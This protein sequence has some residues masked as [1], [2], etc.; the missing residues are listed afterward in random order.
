MNLN[1]HVE[2]FNGPHEEQRKVPGCMCWPGSPWVMCAI[3]HAACRR[4]IQHTH[5]HCLTRPVASST[6][7]PSIP[8]V[9]SSDTAYVTICQVHRHYAR[10]VIAQHPNRLLQDMESYSADQNIF[11]AI[12]GVCRTT[13]NKSTCIGVP[14]TT[15][16]PHAGTRESFGTPAGISVSQLNE[17]FKVLLCRGFDWGIPEPDTFAS[18]T[19][20]SSHSQTQNTKL[21]VEIGHKSK[22][23]VS[24][25]FDR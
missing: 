16:D 18:S 3:I 19:I 25:W 22:F 5:T 13:E 8:R 15:T 24:F 20:S 21:V 14:L 10:S 1:N 12:F 11:P 23:S 6:I 2:S 7:K 4:D 17:K 9:P